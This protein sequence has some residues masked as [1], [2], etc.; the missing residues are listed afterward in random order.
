MSI[1]NPYT[2]TH[3][4]RCVSSHTVDFTDSVIAYAI[5]QS[6]ACKLRQLIT[7]LERLLQS[8]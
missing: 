8:K 4:L 3:S 6:T 7:T 1:H 5:A 2:L